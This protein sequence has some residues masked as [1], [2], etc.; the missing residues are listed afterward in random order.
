MDY[1][2]KGRNK[3]SRYFYRAGKGI[4]VSSEENI[5]LP[6]T[7]LNGVKPPFSVYESEGVVHIIAVGQNNELIYAAG[8]NKE[9]KK[10]SLCTISE[11]LEIIEL[12]T[13]STG[14]R[15]DLL[16]SAGYRGE[17]LLIH[18]VL[19]NQAKPSVIDKMK[20]GDFFLYAGRVYYTN[21]SGDLGYQD[22]S[23]G[24]PDHF[25]LLVNGATDIYIRVFDEDEY[26]IYKK[27]NTIFINHI[28]RFRIREAENPILCRRG[29]S[30]VL[31]FKSGRILEYIDIKSSSDNFKKIMSSTEMIL[32]SVSEYGTVYY[33]Y[34]SGGTGEPHFFEI[35]G[36]LSKSEK[37][38]RLLKNYEYSA[39]NTDLLRLKEE[40]IRLEEKIKNLQ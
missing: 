27:D 36:N 8:K 25:C 30:V 18:C 7:V 10:Y 17:I 1:I 6:E 22:L 35:A 34:A 33:E 26:M 4:L 15:T 13:V 19:G 5:Y 14:G 38:E 31:I 28:P 40:I 32:C 9:L 21:A 23:D 12:K 2:L 11:G 24:K 3:Q 37:G 29:D 20:T 39:I 16:Y